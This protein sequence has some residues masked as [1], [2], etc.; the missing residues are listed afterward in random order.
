MHKTSLAQTNRMLRDLKKRLVTYQAA[1]LFRLSHVGPIGTVA[2]FKLP[3]YLG[4]GVDFLEIRTT[5]R[6]EYLRHIEAI[7]R[8]LHKHDFNVRGRTSW[9][10]QNRRR[11]TAFELIVFPARG[12]I[13]PYEDFVVCQST[14]PRA[15]TCPFDLYRDTYGEN[16]P[17]GGSYSYT[18]TGLKIMLYTRET[19]KKMQAVYS[20]CATVRKRNSRDGTFFVY[21]TFPV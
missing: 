19:A 3:Y 2:D 21:V 13:A 10:R 9:Q 7:V 4:E 14:D 8:I 17:D 16:L 5:N 15:D 1:E 12:E 20:N 11:V 6:L 18:K